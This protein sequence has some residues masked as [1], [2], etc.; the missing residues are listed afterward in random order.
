MFNVGDLVVCVGDEYI[1]HQP[2][3]PKRGNVYEIA[4]AD[5]RFVVLRE[6]PPRK[7]DPM[8]WYVWRF[9]PVRKQSIQ[10]FHDIANGVKQPEKENA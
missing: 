3:A 2:H 6:I 8:G 5:D 7:D 10:L 4:E 1:S 9:R